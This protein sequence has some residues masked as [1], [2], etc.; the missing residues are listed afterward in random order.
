MGFKCSVFG[1]N[2]GETDVERE[3]EENGSEAITTIRETETCTRCGEVRV[4]SENTEVTTLETAADIVADDLDEGSGATIPDAESD[5]AVRTAGAGESGSAGPPEGGE[6]DAVI[7]D[8]EPEETGATTEEE[9]VSEPESL[10]ETDPDEE[11]EILEDTD[12]DEDGE[13]APGE[14]PEEPDDGDDWEQPTDIDRAD[15]EESNG[16]GTV[17]NTVPVPEGEFY[18]PE[19]EY[20][21]A[22]ESSS[23][24]EGDYCP[25]CH[26]G[27]LRHRP[28]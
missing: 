2:W 3:R 18:C 16:F 6:D 11:A 8:D 1:C 21:A 9:E 10:E 28:E 13:R 25:E 27:S 26:R 19:C 12:P 17:G 14:W 23:L 4:V 20:A 24:R 22:V 7:L 5:T 15:D